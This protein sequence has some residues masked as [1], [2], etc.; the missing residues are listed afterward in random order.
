M[1][2]AR[3]V[4]NVQEVAQRWM[5]SVTGFA[6]VS[7]VHWLQSVITAPATTA[8]EDL[9]LE[10]VSESDTLFLTVCGHTVA[11]HEAGTGRETILFL[12]GF[13][14]RFQS[15]SP[16]QA[17]LATRFRTIALDLWGFGASGR[18]AA[19]TPGD[20]VTQ[21]IGTL[22]ALHVSR[23]I[24]A[25]HSLGGRLALMCASRQ[26]ERIQG[27]VLCDPDWGQSPQGYLLAW[28]IAHTPFLHTA[29]R[30][31]RGNPDH[32]R[33]LLRMAYGRGFPITDTLVHRYH[34]PLRVRGTAQTFAR[35]GCA[36]PLRDLRGLPAAVHC[37][38]LVLWGE[39]DPIIPVDWAV[40]LAHK[41][42]TRAPIILPN[43]GHFPQEECPE[44]LVPHI[45]E[46][47]ARCA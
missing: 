34:R 35:L 45:E 23:A 33:R 5:R 18:P 30:Q 12:H 32:V 36:H 21:V 6:G 40:P 2:V 25:G 4:K 3:K 10:Q 39:D 41:L 15:W 47:L 43:T 27:L 20:W 11:Y 13:G 29:L 42:A 14:G 8:D 38:S 22:D 9:S 1:L 7:G 28:G 16:I 17:A 37:P 31:L 19:I 24:L 44:A 26:P 46:F